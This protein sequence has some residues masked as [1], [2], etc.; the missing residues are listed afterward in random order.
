MAG[1]C[2]RWLEDLVESPP[3]RPGATATTPEE[4]ADDFC[5][6]STHIAYEISIFSQR[7]KVR[8]GMNLYSVLPRPAQSAWDRLLTQHAPSLPLA[9]RTSLAIKTLNVRAGDTEKAFVC[10]VAD[11]ILPLFESGDLGLDFGRGRRIYHVPDLASIILSASQCKQ[12]DHLQRLFA[13]AP[14]RLTHFFYLQLLEAHAPNPR[15]GG[16]PYV[17]NRRDRLVQVRER[18]TKSAVFFFLFNTAIVTNNSYAVD[19]F[20]NRL[21]IAKICPVGYEGNHDVCPGEHP[22]PRDLQSGLPFARRLFAQRAS[23]RARL[24]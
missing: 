13:A 8:W 19:V 12:G 24:F 2:I 22:G 5:T 11:E 6:L 4:L 1:L 14:R 21:F 9:A 10:S 3:R 16:G 23:A 17:G 15:G 18:A 7:I 20:F